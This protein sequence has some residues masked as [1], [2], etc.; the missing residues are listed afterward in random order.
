MGS[1]RL[2]GCAGV[3]PRYAG[4]NGGLI[5]S[6]MASADSADLLDLVLRPHR[7]LT[8]S[9]FR[10]LMIV[11]AA[12]GIGSGVVVLWLGAWPVLG[13]L[14]ADVILV[15]LAFK[16]SYAAG[17]AYERVR[18]SESALTVESV[19]RWGRRRA[20]DLQPHWL[21]VDI[22]EAPSG[23]TLTS[24]G[25]TVAIASFLPPDELDDVADTIRAALARLRDPMRR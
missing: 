2:D 16:V 14:G 13:F 7:S 10:A 20:V 1:F 8:P 5:L 4:G 24:R 17:R 21:R 11:L 18:L 23:L 15:Y 12:F 19:D 9:G 3:A 22:S 6:V 25:H